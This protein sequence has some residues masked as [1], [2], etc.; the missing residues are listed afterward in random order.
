M[1]QK[2]SASKP[3]ST[4]S[5]VV[6][7]EQTANHTQKKNEHVISIDTYRRQSAKH[8]ESEATVSVREIYTNQVE[9]PIR[10]IMISSGFGRQTSLNTPTIQ[11]MA[12]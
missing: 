1:D 7:W 8:T 3:S 5:S 2:Q 12:A 11:G 9:E 4:A 6:V 10:L